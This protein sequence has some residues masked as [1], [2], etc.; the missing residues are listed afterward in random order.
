[1]KLYDWPHAAA[2]GR[3]IPKNSIYQHA[4]AGTALRDI[5]VREVGQIVWSYKLAA[6]TINLV[7]AN[8]VTEIQVI[9]ITTRIM[10][11]NYDVLRVIDEAIPFP[12][13][14]EVIHDGRVKLVA[15]YKRL[16][17]AN[18]ARCRV[19]DY[20][21]GSWL[22][23]NA[24][25]AQFP[26]ALNMSVLYERLLEPLVVEDTVRFVQSTGDVPQ[27]P[28]TA[29]N[30]QRPVSLEG[31]IA[32]A[33]AVRAKALDVKRVKERLAQEKQ[34]NKRVAINAKLRIAKHE[35]ERLSAANHAATTAE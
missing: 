35:L 9:H 17:D 32:Q 23:E 16:S 21:E 26:V 6:E 22:P 27:T 18:S 5:F 20:F 10:K 24:P 4:G 11:L 14:F 15:A 25:R 1:M 33:E 12:L 28:F 7:P 8:Q 3:V 34:F 30:P 31:R 13:F 19:S 2:F 29:V